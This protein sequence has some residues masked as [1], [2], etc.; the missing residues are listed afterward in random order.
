MITPSKSVLYL[1]EHI[2]C[3][4]SIAENGKHLRKW[5]TAPVLTLDDCYNGQINMCQ[6][7]PN[8]IT[9]ES[10]YKDLEQHKNKENQEHAESILQKEGAKYYVSSHKGKSDYVRFKFKT[11]Q[12]ITQKLRL[13]IIR[14]LAKEGLQFDEGFKSTNFV[15]PVPNRPHW[16]HT[17]NDERIIKEVDGTDL[18]IDKLGIKEPPRTQR[19]S[20]TQSGSTPFFEPKDR[21]EVKGWANSISIIKF[22]KKHN[23]ESCHICNTNLKFVDSHGLYYC[24]T[25]KTGGGLKKFAMLILKSKG[26]KQ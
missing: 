24:P 10:D 17:H 26:V 14:Y 3:K 2:G 15:R 8:E 21:G 7:L 13:E 11:S 25:C 5:S 4:W 12:P 6:E 22:A 20:P 18:D 9:L 16:K 23:F 1:K 19:Q